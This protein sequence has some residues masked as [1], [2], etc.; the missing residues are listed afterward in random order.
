[1][2]KIEAVIQPHKLEDVREAL[3]SIGIPAMSI[4]EVRG[5]GR[6]NGH[7]DIHHLRTQYDLDVLPKVKVEMVVPDARGEEVIS[8]PSPRR[9]AREGSATA[10]S[11]FSKS[12]RRSASATTSEGTARSNPIYRSCRALLGHHR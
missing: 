7:E 5:H 9:P 8:I 12:Q 2:K 11:L 6:Q 4:T 1:M 3:K 10:T